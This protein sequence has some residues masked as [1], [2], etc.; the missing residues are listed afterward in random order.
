M[1]SLQES[2]Q[3]EIRMEERCEWELSNLPA[4]MYQLYSSSQLSQL[5][6]NYLEIHCTLTCWM[7]HRC[8][9]TDPTLASP[10][11]L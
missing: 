6:H 4:R 2:Q 9:S 10:G 5:L 11:S 1:N 8:T 7:L 3:R